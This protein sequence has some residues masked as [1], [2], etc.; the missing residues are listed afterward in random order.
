MTARFSLQKSCAVID[1]AYSRR[2]F[3]VSH[4]RL[5]TRVVLDYISIRSAVHP[6]VAVPQREAKPATLLF[7]EHLSCAKS[8]AGGH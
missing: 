4:E 1:R 2:K 7:D 5:A 8:E 6:G 3:K